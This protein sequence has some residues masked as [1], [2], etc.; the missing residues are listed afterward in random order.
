M[1]YGPDLALAICLAT[2]SER[3]AGRT[4][5]VADPEP[6]DLHAALEW[7]AEAVGRPVRRV[8]VPEALVRA[9]GLVAE[10]LAWFAGAVPAFSRDKV[11]EFLA[12]GWVCDSSRA[13]DELGWTPRAPLRAAMAETAAWYRN[14]GWI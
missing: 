6:V 4:Y 5:H 7:I 14:A 2:E 11:A 10:E 12:S 8:T 3:A 1:V 9:V 13:R